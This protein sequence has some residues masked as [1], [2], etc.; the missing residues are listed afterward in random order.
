MVKGKPVVIT[1]RQKEAV[2]LKER[3]ASGEKLLDGWVDGEMDGGR[4]N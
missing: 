4:G 3:A 2:D 1:V